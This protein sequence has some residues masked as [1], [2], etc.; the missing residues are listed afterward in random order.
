VTSSFQDRIWGL[1]KNVIVYGLKKHLS[2]LLEV[3]EFGFVCVQ[4]K[5]ST[6]VAYRIAA[7]AG[8]G[9]FKLL[10]HIFNHSLTVQTQEGPAH[11]LR[12]NRVSTDNLSADA[13]E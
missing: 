10:F 9:V 1:P 4:E 7:N 5:T 8:L 12:V 6:V 13:H 11:Q 3:N 2:Y